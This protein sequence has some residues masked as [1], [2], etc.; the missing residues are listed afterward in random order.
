[1]YIGVFTNYLILYVQIKFYFTY[2]FQ[3][4]LT[5]IVKN[6]IDFY[7]VF[8]LKRFAIKETF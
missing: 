2:K 1:M 6:I 5:K 4:Q 7:F 8:T 3:F